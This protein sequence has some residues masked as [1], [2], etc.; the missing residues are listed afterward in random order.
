MTNTLN[1]AQNKFVDLMTEDNLYTNEQL[2]ALC[3]VDVRTVYRWKKNE[4]IAQEIER[5]ADVN[6]KVHINRAYGVLTD[7]LFSPEANE[8]I[9]LKALDLFLKT[10]GKLKDRSESEIEL[11]VKDADQ[12]AA[13]LDKL[14]NL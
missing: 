12:A 5:N 8:N 9:K 6:L 10:Q 2:A 4:A 7:I 13:D 11:K 14:L 1:A 3:D